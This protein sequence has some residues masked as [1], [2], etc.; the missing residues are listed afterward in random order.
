LTRSEAVKKANAA[1]ARLSQSRF[2]NATVR[3]RSGKI[4]SSTSSATNVTASAKAVTRRSIVGLSQNSIEE[5]MGK[6]SV[7]RET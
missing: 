3:G 5:A 7:K 4:C 1:M 6:G 2:K